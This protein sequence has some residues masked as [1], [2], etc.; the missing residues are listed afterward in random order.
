MGQ[1]PGR[2]SVFSCGGENCK[3]GTPHQWDGP[4]LSTETSESAT[5]SKCGMD[6]ISW[7][8]WNSPDPRPTVWDRVREDNS[9]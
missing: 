7:C 5:C 8:L 1:D 9:D 2:V 3:D 6:M 4:T